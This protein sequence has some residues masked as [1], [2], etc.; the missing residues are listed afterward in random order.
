MSDLNLVWRTD[1][2]YDYPLLIKNLL[3]GPVV[4]DPDREIV[5]RGELRFTY[6]QFRERVGRLAAA[7]VALGVKP[8]DT[9]AMMDWDS[10][11]YLECFYAVPMIG[12]VLHTVNVRLS[13]EQLVYTIG[14]AEDDVVL[15]NA[16]FLP[17]IEH[18]KGRIETVRD[19][20]LINDGD[21]APETTLP[22][23]GEYEQLL[24]AAEP[25]TE[26]PDFD[27]NTRATTFYSTGTTGLPKGVYFSHRQLV[28]HTLGT[29]ATIASAATCRLSREDVYM[30][31]TPMFHVHAWGIPYIATLFGVKQ[32]YPG[33]YIPEVLLKMLVSEQVTFS[34]CVPTILHMLV[35]SPAAKQFDLSHW[36]VLIGGAALPRSVAVA[37]LERGIDVAVGYGLS[38]TA[39]VLTVTNLS[40]AERELPLEEQAVLRIRTGTPIA[41][42][43][44][45]VVD[46]NGAEVPADDRTSGE[47]VVRAPW[48]TQGYFKDHANSERLWEG[49]WMHTQDIAVRNAA[50]SIRITDRAKDI[51]KI[52]GEWMSSLELE[53]I[54]AIHPAVAEVAVIGRPDDKWGEV[55]LGLAV[56]KEGEAVTENDLRA[57]VKSFIDAGVLPR[58]ALLT[59][60]R[61]IDAVD[62]TGIG[63]VNKVALREKY[64]D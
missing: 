14:H 13:P 18:I 42:V 28:L 27:E 12:A 35:S 47:I 61:F 37:A 64:L 51:I 34:H 38:E 1:S 63:K 30:P 39:P 24:A 62:R 3:R 6:R 15:V 55:P 57:H 49:G 54:I 16:E 5:Y 17:L 8:G 52:G 48:L 25:M 19:Y 23:S 50:G 40:D 26:F 46:E 11:R 2:A 58:E 21:T 43:D 31:L 32:V 9:V 56:R 44:L 41:M 45:K 22:L 4:D 33:K 29:A 10:H 7:L 36:K 59:E 20:V 53:D 60:I